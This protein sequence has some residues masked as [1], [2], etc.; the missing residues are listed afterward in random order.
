MNQVLKPAAATGRVLNI[1]RYCSHDGPGI[2]TNVFLKG[3]SLRCKWCGNPESIRP[4]PEL[5]Y[6]PRTCTG[7][8]ACGLCLK[9]PFPEGAFYVVE[10]D[11]DKVRV[12]WDLAG[13]C[14]EALVAL[15]PTGALSM[16]G[17]TMTVDEV[18]DEVEKDSSFYRNTGGGITLSGG[19]CLLQP[20][21]SAAL[22]AGA[23]ERGINTA[24]ETACNVPWAFV[25]KVLPHVDTMLHDHKLTIPERHLKWTGAS[26]ERILANFKKAYETF[27]DIDF[28]ARTPLIPG[29]NADEEHIRAVL[30]FIRPHKNVIDYELLPYHRFGLG[31]YEHLGKVYELDDYR[32]PSDEVVR[33]LRAI[34][35]EA[36]GRS[37][38]ETPAGK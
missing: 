26:N 31:K 29:V 3:C 25:E 18:L 22:L 9:P 24:I 20:D 2:R 30:A 27:P 10:G 19:E 35:D 6:D 17:K 23:H 38:Q 14:D 21:F 34:I 12:N 15:C 5:A 4:K 32:T 13:G 28:I 1:Q 16:F 11:D 33:H 36:F 37:S 7:K 8:K